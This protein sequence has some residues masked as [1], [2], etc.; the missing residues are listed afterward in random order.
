MA[1]PFRTRT[2]TDREMVEYLQMNG[3][4]PPASKG[5]PLANPVN[6]M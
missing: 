5:K 1:K 6:E 3:I 2:G 4:A